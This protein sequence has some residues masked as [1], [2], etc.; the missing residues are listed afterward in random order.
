MPA[1]MYETLAFLSNEVLTDFVLYLPKLVVALL[2]LVI[3]AALAKTFKR[4]LVKLMEALRLSNTFKKTPV[5]HFLTDADLGGKVEEVVGTVMYWLVMLVVIHTTVSILGLTSLTILIGKILSY[6]PN[7][8]SSII[9]LFFGLLIAGIVESLVKGAVK[10]V[11]GKSSRLLGKVS[12]YAVMVIT[13]LAAISELGIAQEFIF[14][15]FVGFVI[16]VSLATGLAFGLGG[17][18]VVNMALTQWYKKTKSE[19]S[20][21]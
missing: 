2:V 19:V 10:S 4:V 11:D 9:I 21:K 7:L 3:G 15:L 20:K 12:S 8:F 5:E 13:V 16:T 17:K 6:L 1:K 18:D 14:I